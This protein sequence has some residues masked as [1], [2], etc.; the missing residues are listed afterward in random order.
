MKKI[1]T[2]S[3]I[4]QIIIVFLWFVYLSNKEN[5]QKIENNIVQII[6]QDEISK[7]NKNP[8]WLFDDNYNLSKNI[9]SWFWIDKN[10][11]LTIA[12]WVNSKD[13]IYKVKDIY[14]NN[15]K[16]IL[17]YKNT[18][19]DIAIIKTNKDFEKFVNYKKSN[20]YYIW[21]T[22]YSISYTENKIKKTKWKIININDSE[23]N[24]NIKFIDWDSWWILVDK[25][26]N[27]IWIN[28]WYNI[29]KNYSISTKI[30]D[31]TYFSK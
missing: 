29:E 4:I 28:N 8:W 9:F 25:K 1:V 16:W 21:D 13:S 26:N 6:K 27:I 22:V 24:T 7:I 2:I 20:N 17:D 23:I 19:K 14:W 10:T 11:I 30:K 3:I 15:Y 18:K 5:N 31:I 12:H